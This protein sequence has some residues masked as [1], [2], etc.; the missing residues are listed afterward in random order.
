MSDGKVWLTR[1]TWPDGSLAVMIDV[2]TEQPKRWPSYGGGC[3]WLSMYS[4]LRG[5]KE[6]MGVEEAIARFRTIP[7]TDLECVAIGR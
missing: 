5:H 3:V 6:S 2:W 1:D 4:S 7:E